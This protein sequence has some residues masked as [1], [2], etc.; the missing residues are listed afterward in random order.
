MQ[1][2][3][4]KSLARLLLDF[5]LSAGRT[6]YLAACFTSSGL[7]GSA[8]VKVQHISFSLI[9]RPLLANYVRYKLLSPLGKN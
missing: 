3:E 2:S 6:R 1:F 9:N 7:Q 5:S 8:D 4:T